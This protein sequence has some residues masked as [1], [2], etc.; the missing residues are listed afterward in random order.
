MPKKSKIATKVTKFHHFSSGSIS[1]L[2]YF[3]EHVL[4]ERQNNGH[5]KTIHLIS[6]V[7]FNKFENK[8]M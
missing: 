2:S 7:G 3:G 8:N 4:T 6:A 5:V 1:W